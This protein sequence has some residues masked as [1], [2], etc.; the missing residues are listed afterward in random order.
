[1]MRDKAP[2]LI[3]LFHSAFDFSDSWNAL[4]PDDDMENVVLDM[5]YYQAFD[6]YHHDTIQPY[7]DEYE[8]GM[9]VAETIKY[10][11]WNGEW[12]LGTDTC[13]MWLGG[14]N[15]IKLIPWA[16]TCAW[17]D[18]PKTYMPDEGVD[19]DRTA[20]EIGPFGSSKESG[21]KKG[22]CPI[23]SDFFGSDDMQVLG[24]CAL[25][26]FDNHTTAQFLWTFRNE[27]EPKWDYIKAYDAGW[28][29][30]SSSEEEFLQ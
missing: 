1:M 26:A 12:S 28:L 24:K 22:K 25:K 3:F 20:A 17:V 16:H 29:K 19:F 27:L 13:A 14:F 5:H 15:D 23:D 10:P 2:H 30:R 6:G 11:V 18:C 4:F 21:V 9:A 8:S 7:C